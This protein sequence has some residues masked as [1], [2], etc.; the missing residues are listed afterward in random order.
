MEGIALSWSSGKDSALSL[1]YLLKSRGFEVRY[2]L[3]T[4]TESYSRVSM[5]GVREGLVEMQARSIGIEL[6]KVYIPMNC[7][8]EVYEERM[9][10]ACIEMMEQG[11]TGVAFGDIFLEDVREYREKNLAKLGMECIF[12]IWGRSTSELAREFMRLG[13]RAKVICVDLE[14]LPPSHAGRE[15]DLDFLRDL[16]SGCDPCGENGEFHTF[17]YSGPWFKQP[18]EIKLGES[19]VRNDRFCFRDIL[20]AEEDL[21]PGI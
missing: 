16:P 11:I 13:F 12:P 17:V 15:Y 18:I 9:R 2:L 6:K 4:I 19:V 3:T 20:P 5:H 7:T 8:N 10:R 14:K 21:G 1:H